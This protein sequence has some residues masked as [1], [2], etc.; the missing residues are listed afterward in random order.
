[1]TRETPDT[2]TTHWQVT[3]LC[4]T[5]GMCADC[6]LGHT[7]ARVLHADRLTETRA[8]EMARNWSAYHAMAAPMPEAR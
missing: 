1:M 8:R 7:P 2:M 4:C 3:R 5:S 6:G